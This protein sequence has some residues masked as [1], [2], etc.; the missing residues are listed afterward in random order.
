MVSAE[1]M[2]CLSKVSLFVQCWGDDKG[3]KSASLLEEVIPH[4]TF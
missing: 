3:G 2:G 1:K 4:E